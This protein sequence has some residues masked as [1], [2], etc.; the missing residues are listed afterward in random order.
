[1]RKDDISIM[2]YNLKT[3]TKI[4]PFTDSDFEL[5]IPWLEDFLSESY[6]VSMEILKKGSLQR[7]AT[8]SSR[9]QKEKP[10]KMRR[11]FLRRT[12]GIMSAERMVFPFTVR[13]MTAVPISLPM[14]FPL[15]NEAATG[16]SLCWP[17]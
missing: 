14:P 15:Q 6:M 12:A 17:K 9:Q 7:C 4:I 3:I 16:S 13:Q 2:A 11:P 1:M 10:V 5:Y 8:G